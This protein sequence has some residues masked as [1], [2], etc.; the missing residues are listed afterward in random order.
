MSN[1][2][3]VREHLRTTYKL[4]DDVGEFVSI[5]WGFPDD[6]SQKVVVRTFKAF[7]QELVEIKSAF[8]K[9]ATL[10]ANALLA[11]NAE[12]PLGT[13]ALSGDVYFVVYNTL[14]TDLSDSTLKLMMTEVATVADSLEK[15]FGT[16]DR[17]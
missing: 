1:W 6:R 11:R 17:Y 4:E 12:L 7:E 13:I 10:D 2:T 16:G 8:A 14:L 5:V 15:Q 9:G 3:A